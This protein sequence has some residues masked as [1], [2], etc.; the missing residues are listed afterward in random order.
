M[1]DA[2]VGRMIGRKTRKRRRSRSDAAGE[3]GR[4]GLQL[5]NPAAGARLV[6]ISFARERPKPPAPSTCTLERRVSIRH[7]RSFLGLGMILAAVLVMAAMPG[8]AQNK[9]CQDLRALWQGA[10][11]LDSSGI[12]HWGGTVVAVIGGEVLEGTVT[13]VVV[14]FRRETSR[15]VGMDRGTQYRYGFGGGDTYRT[16]KQPASKPL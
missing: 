11:I 10:L 1:D 8:R 3:P 5:P 12:P 15:I 6:S 16:A 7:I 14:R 2:A 9:N 4:L 13:E